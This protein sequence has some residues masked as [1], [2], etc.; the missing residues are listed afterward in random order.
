MSKKNA[1]SMTFTELVIQRRGEEM[2]RQ[3]PSHSFINL[4]TNG[5]RDKRR[6]HKA[7]LHPPE[8]WG[9]D[10]RGQ[11]VDVTKE[12]G[13]PRRAT[14]ISSNTSPNSNMNNIEQQ[15]AHILVKTFSSSSSVTIVPLVHSEWSAHVYRLS[16]TLRSASTCRKALVV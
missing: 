7:K 6:V 14:N 4:G 2:L 16:N 13:A 11:K 12:H 3:M 10:W 15:N 8:C 5:E 9:Y 1:A